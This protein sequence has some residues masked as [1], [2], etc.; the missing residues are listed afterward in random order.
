MTALRALIAYE[1]LLREFQRHLSAPLGF[2]ETLESGLGYLMQRLRLQ[3]VGLFWWDK[4]RSILQMQYSFQD[5]ALMEGEEEILIEQNGALADLLTGERPVIISSR[6]PWIAYLPIHSGKKFIG[7]VRLQRP[8]PLPKGAVLYGL[9]SL[10]TSEETRERVYP[11][12]E[13]L[14][15]IL[16]NKLQEIFREKRHRKKEQAFQA[17]ADVAS[18]VVEMPRLRD[19]LESVARSIVK[20]LGLDRVRVYLV[21]PNRFSLDGVIGI[22]MPD[23]VLNLDA[24]KYN[25]HEATNALADVVR[26]GTKEVFK[27]TA[28][29]KVVYLPLVVA[30]DIVGVILADNLLSQQEIDEEQLGALKTL[31]GQVGMAIANARQFE[32]IEQQ[33]ITD[34]LTKLYVYRYFQ[35]RLKEELDRADRYSYS[36]ALIM[37]DADYFKSLND[38]YGHQLGDKVLEFLAQ[39]IRGNIR[40]IDLAARYGGD[41]FVLL[42]PEITEQEA[43]LMAARLL[44]ALKNCNIKAPTGE[45]IPVAVTMGAA[46]YPSDAHNGRDLIECADQALYWSKKNTRGDICF[47]RN[48]SKTVEKTA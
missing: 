23:R 37:M 47:F 11:L 26:S 18:A 25:L 28:D 7:A 15:D 17:G 1:E 16:S 14:G 10:R 2:E 4:N 30:R 42:L 8:L 5:G 38:S 36:V 12:L 41:E 45:S 32:D 40:R 34:G 20:H 44:N 39:T 33:A 22:Q 3:N 9:P 19:M 46:L 21:D 35:Q 48:V 29:G 13:D 31:A 6:R 43:W 27:D 24:E